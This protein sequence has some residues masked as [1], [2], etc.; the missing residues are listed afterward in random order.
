MKNPVST[1]VVLKPADIME[2]GMQISKMKNNKSGLDIFII[3]LVKYV[4][5]EIVQG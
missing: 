1:S 4:K 5:N 2:V 3:N